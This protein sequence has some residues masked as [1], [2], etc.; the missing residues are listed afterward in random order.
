MLL[1]TIINVPEELILTSS[2]LMKAYPTLGKVSKLLQAKLCK[3]KNILAVICKV[4]GEGV[5]WKAHV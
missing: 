1:A 4:C 3:T 2:K 5:S